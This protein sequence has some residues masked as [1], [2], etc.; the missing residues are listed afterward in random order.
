M[1]SF[2]RRAAQPVAEPISLS[3]ALAHLR[4]SSGVEDEY[5][6]TLIQVARESCENR[7]EKTMIQTTWV[8]TLDKFPDAI[9]LMMPPVIAIASVQYVDE[10]GVTQV[11]NPA[12]Y[13]LDKAREPG[14]LVP[15]PGREWP[16]TSFGINQV[17][18]TYT[19]GY[20]ASGASVPAPLRHWMLLALTDLYENRA[21]HGEKPA[22]RHSFVD[23]LLDP[24]RLLG[25]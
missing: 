24:Y 20:G 21:A 7:T 5:I 4:V 14:W 19:A 11:L 10:A 18:V 22:V 13:V 15:A 12:D 25:V 3:Q 23:S 1:K 16:A 17:I 6:T 2:P 9:E 8:L